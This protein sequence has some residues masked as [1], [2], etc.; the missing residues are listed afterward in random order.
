VQVG[1]ILTKTTKINKKMLKKQILTEIAFDELAKSTD[2]RKC[3]QNLQL[4]SYETWLL[5]Q[6]VA[7]FGNWQITL[8]SA[9]LVDVKSTLAHNVGV[10]LWQ[11]GVLLAATKLQRGDLVAKQTAESGRHYS[12]LVPLVLAGVRQ[13][14]NIRYEQWR[15]AGLEWVVPEQLAAAMLTEPPEIDPQLLLDLR[16]LGLQQRGVARSPTSA[17][18]LYGLTGTS[19]GSAPALQQTML[20]Q[21]WVAHPTLRTANMVLDPENWDS[22][23]APLIDSLVLDTKPTLPPWMQ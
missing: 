15:T 21:T 18:R 1:V 22:M 10:D 20:T 16:A 5:P 14:Q 7:H 2:L 6:L 23:P 12:A 13:S 9:G 19:L 8:D 3:A 4:A 17:A 11:L